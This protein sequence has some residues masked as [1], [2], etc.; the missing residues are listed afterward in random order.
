M[1]FP[2]AQWSLLTEAKWASHCTVLELCQI[3][4][5]PLVSVWKRWKGNDLQT[6]STSVA[7]LGKSRSEGIQYKTQFT[8]NHFG[9]RM[10]GLACECTQVFNI[11]KLF[12][13]SHI[14]MDLFPFVKLTLKFSWQRIC[15]PPFNH[16]DSQ[17][18]SLGLVE[19]KTLVYWIW[20]TSLNKEIGNFQK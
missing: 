16:Q 8:A 19:S 11:N 20:K 10:K 7:Q 15:S 2:A 12:K 13:G 9:W 6:M 1:W 17:F 4:V 3:T 14:G 5:L 18:T